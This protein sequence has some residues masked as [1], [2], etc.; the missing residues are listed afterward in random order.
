MKSNAPSRPASSAVA[1]VPCA[2]DDHDRQR[3][4]RAAQPA[5]HLEAVHARHLDVEEHEV[6]RLALDDREP[7]LAASRATSTS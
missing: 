6:G 3:L 4:V 2:G 5:Q 1:A 7:F